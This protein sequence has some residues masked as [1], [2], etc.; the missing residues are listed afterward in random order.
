M[1]II[2][3]SFNS[4]IC[5]IN[6]GLSLRRARVIGERGAKLDFLGLLFSYMQ[7]D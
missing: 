6:E 2:L 5:R 3:L 1:V 4:I 7:L